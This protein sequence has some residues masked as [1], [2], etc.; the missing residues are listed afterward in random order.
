MQKRCIQFIYN[1]RTT[2]NYTTRH[3]SDTFP[4]RFRYD[5]AYRRFVPRI[6]FAIRPVSDCADMYIVEDMQYACPIK[7]V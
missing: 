4:I 5:I 6:E 3:V 1:S 7:L 2:H